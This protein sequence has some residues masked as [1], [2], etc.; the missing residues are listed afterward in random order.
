[1]NFAKGDRKFNFFSTIATLKIPYDI[2]LQE[3]LECLFPAN[4][5]T[6]ENMRKLPRF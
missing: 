5:V 1:M 2:T 3:L 4:H 6:E